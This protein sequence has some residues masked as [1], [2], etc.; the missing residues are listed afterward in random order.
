LE[1]TIMDKK[2]FKE[3]VLEMKKERDRIAAQLRYMN[4]L[5]KA[6]N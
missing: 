6:V 4:R 2:A 3:M 1:V 5:I